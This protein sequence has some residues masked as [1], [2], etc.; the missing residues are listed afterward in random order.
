[1]YDSERKKNDEFPL[2][3][4]DAMQKMVNIELISRAVKPTSQFSKPPA[5]LH[6]RVSVSNDRIVKLRMDQDLNSDKLM[7]YMA[8]YKRQSAWEII[9]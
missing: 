6:E 3:L 8:M 2:D 4:L 1:M 7:D 9:R 5:I